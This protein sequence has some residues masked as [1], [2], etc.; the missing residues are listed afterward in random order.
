M[1]PP[2]RLLAALTEPMAEALGAVFVATTR[3]WLALRNFTADWGRACKDWKEAMNQA[4]IL[5]EDR[6]TNKV[7]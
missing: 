3:I 2:G 1:L 6:F 5:Y 4:A 7:N